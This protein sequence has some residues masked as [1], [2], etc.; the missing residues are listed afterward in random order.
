M[1][2]PLWVGSPQS[3]VGGSWAWME[4]VDVWT[5]K[6]ASCHRLRDPEELLSHA[7]H[8]DDLGL[9]VIREALSTWKNCT[10]GELMFHPVFWST[11]SPKGDCPWKE[12]PMFILDPTPPYPTFCLRW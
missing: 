10:S 9:K 1:E 6:A 5:S 3:C 11:T 12:V 7:V 8:L 4:P 2:G